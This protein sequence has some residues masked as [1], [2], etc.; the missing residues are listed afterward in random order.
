[1]A[2]RKSVAAPRTHHSPIG[3]LQH[4]LAIEA[5]IDRW[6]ETPK[7]QGNDTYIVHLIT[8]TTDLNNGQQMAILFCLMAKKPRRHCTSGE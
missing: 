2:R 1:M 8:E 7:N 5:I 6:Y 3:L 4:W